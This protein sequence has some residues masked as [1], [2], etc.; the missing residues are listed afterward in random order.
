[1][2]APLRITYVIPVHNEEAVLP[3]TTAA[4]VARLAD[5]PGSEVILVENGS[6]DSTP[7]LVRRLAAE[8]STA[9]V[10][11]RATT[12]AKGYG[13][14]QRAGIALSTG[15]LVVLHAADLPFEFSDLDAALARDPRPP[16]MIGSKAHPDSVVAIPT[17]RRVMSFGFRVVRRFTVGLSA[18]DT[19]GS[20][21]VDGNL[22]RRLHRHA[23]CEDYLLTTELVACAARYGVTAVE[24][25]VRYEN[26]RP[27]SK[28]RPVADS[29]HMLAGLLA[30]RRRLRAVSITADAVATVPAAAPVGAQR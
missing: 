9:S 15:E 28:V 30:L 16:L 26:P 7:A 25:P 14:A 18:R 11:V 17:L 12:S 23:R 10:T 21:L 4:I 3:A 1:M 2:T 6:T 24:I 8:A 20:L 5:H 13:N 22:L 29:L 19:Q 27:D